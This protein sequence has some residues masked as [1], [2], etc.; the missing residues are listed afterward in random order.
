MAC[1]SV[2]EVVMS[3]VRQ[4]LL[5]TK[6]QIITEIENELIRKLE[7]TYSSRI[8]SL[9]SRIAKLEQQISDQG[10]EWGLDGIKK[11]ITTHK[12]DVSRIY[13]GFKYNGW[14]YYPNEEMGDFLYKVRED[15]SQNTQLTDYSI[16][17]YFSIN[18]GYLYFRDNKWNDRKIKLED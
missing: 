16:R 8:S 4:N 9:E 13:G 3:I 12:I 14:I 2:Q 10:I 6:P 15:G 18:N 17:S 11:K 7:K 1:D 5:Q